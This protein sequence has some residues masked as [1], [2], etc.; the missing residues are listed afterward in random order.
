MQDKTEKI[1]FQESGKCLSKT[2]CYAVF[3]KMLWSSI[4]VTLVAKKFHMLLFADNHVSRSY[5]TSP[6]YIG[7]PS[8]ATQCQNFPTILYG[9]CLSDKLDVS[10][11][12]L[13]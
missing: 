4:F 5:V 8:S 13:S 10:I 3:L 6:M 2:C 11:C 1:L 9:R 7:F 12:I